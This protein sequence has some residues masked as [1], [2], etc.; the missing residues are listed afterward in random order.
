MLKAQFIMRRTTGDEMELRT[1]FLCPGRSVAASS[2]SISGNKR[3]GTVCQ[4]RAEVRVAAEN[5][6]DKKGRKS[7]AG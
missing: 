3:Q 7:K 5:P 1:R 4:N 2:A 6:G